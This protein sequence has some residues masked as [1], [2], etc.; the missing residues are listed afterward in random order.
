MQYEDL[1]LRSSFTW[2][3]KLLVNEGNSL[4]LITNRSFYSTKPIRNN[5]FDVRSEID[6]SDLNS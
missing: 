5:K 2:G 1:I 3:K 4:I 6:V